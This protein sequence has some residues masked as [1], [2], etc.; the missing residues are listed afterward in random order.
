M[1]YQTLNITLEDNAARITLNR[2]NV[3]NALS[4][5][6][7]SELQNTLKEVADDPT[8]RAVLLT[9]AGRGFSSGADLA[10]TSVE[11]NIGEIIEDSYNP[12]ARLIHTMPKPVVAGVNGIAAGA[13]MSLALC[14]DVR[15]L[16]SDAAFAV[17]FTGIALVMD[18]SGSYFLPRLVGRSRALELAYTNRKVGA[19]EALALGLGETII[20]AENFET[21]AFGLVKRL[22]AGPTQTFGFVKQQINASSH[23]DLEAQLKLEADLQSKA[24]ASADAAEGVA[25]FKAKRKPEFKGK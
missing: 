10:E 24:A 6:L 13:G 5:E 16:S 4:P 17:G 21:E 3:L 2:P 9:G 8:V 7:L 15:L 19:E 18:A 22:A 20:P 25:A 23:N 12:V 1:S 14:C 11:G